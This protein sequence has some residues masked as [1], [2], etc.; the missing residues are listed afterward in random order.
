VGFGRS[1][2]VVACPQPPIPRA[3]VAP[4]TVHVFCAQR[5]QVTDFYRG[6]AVI[7]GRLFSALCLG[8]SQGDVEKERGK[9]KGSPHGAHCAVA[10]G[11][12]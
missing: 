8:R 11:G 9:K 7:L 3:S 6:A 2:H 12:G 1:G 10:S 5:E 4:S